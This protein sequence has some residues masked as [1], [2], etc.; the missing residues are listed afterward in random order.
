MRA[1]KTSGGNIGADL[2]QQV[3]NKSTLTRKV[4]RFENNDV[5][6][7]LRIIDQFENAPVDKNVKVG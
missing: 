4:I 1:K 2:L 7:Y 5:P 6:E 3:S